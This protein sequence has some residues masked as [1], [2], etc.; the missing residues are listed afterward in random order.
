MLRIFTRGGGQTEQVADPTAL[1]Y[2]LE[3]PSDEEERAVEATLGIDV[4]TPIER[5]AFEESARFYEECEALHLTVTLLGRREEGRFVSGPVSFILAKDKLVTVRQIKP[6][7]FDVGQGRAS[8]RVGSAKNGADMFVALLEGIVERLSDVLAEA[9][10]EVNDM[11]AIV[12]TETN[13]P[14]LRQCLRGL[15]K[16]GAI[17]ALSQDSLSSLQR[18]L[19]F[20]R[21]AC[22]RH[23]LSDERLKALERDVAE[24][25]R[26]AEALQSRMSYIQDAALGLINATQTDVLK[27]L[28]VATIAFVPATLIASIFGMNFTAMHWFQE[29]WGPW[30]AFALMVF[31]PAALF[32]LAKWRG[33]F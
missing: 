16:A 4:P 2:D 20:A 9:T 19:A 8:A 27:A 21:L 11:S 26:L 7:A 28:S 13:A 6:R 25:E 3:T 17:T 30:A 29:G 33:W 15:G 22:T 5:A 31:A 23:N 14:N 12:F 18:M 24:L 10:N 32:G 1:W